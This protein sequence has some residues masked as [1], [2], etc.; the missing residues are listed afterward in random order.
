MRIRD[1]L[2]ISEKT[3][4]DLTRF[5]QVF[6]VGIMF[7]GL[8]VGNTKV[9][10]NGGMGLAVTF[11]P[12]FLERKYSI[13]L[14]AG[15]ALWITS[16]VFLHAIGAVSVNGSHLYGSVW[17]WDHMT[18]TLSASVVTAAGYTTIR[19][20]EEHSDELHFPRKLM[21]A[22]ILIFILALGV[23]WEILEFAITMLSELIGME[24]ILTQYGLED[25]MKDLIFNTIGAIIVATFG[26]L[27]LKGTIEQTTEYIKN[28]GQNL[29]NY[30]LAN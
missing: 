5:M 24:T 7:F 11:I 12:G 6:L 30:E 13:T 29:T 18:H 14:D 17:W 26:D 9:I 23:F 21:F 15:L 4:E 8:Y 10:V 25:T 20:F 1:R 19:A 3:Q 22:F 27:Y 28:K 16:A 2:G